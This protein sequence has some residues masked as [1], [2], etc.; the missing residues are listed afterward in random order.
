MRLFTEIHLTGK[1]I[2]IKQKKV[3]GERERGRER[4][5]R[6][7]KRRKGGERKAERKGPCGSPGAPIE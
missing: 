2:D 6:R 7:G 4:R 5:G 3:G 1:T